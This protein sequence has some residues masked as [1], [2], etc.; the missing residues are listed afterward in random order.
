VK[1]IRKSLEVIIFYYKKKKPPSMIK[2]VKRRIRQ[3]NKNKKLKTS[4]P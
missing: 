2:V 1:T 4:N 3:V